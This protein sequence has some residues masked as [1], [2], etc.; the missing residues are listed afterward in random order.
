MSN[1]FIFEIL[2]VK[3]SG[4]FTSQFELSTIFI[5]HLPEFKIIEYFHEFDRSIG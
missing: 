2:S 3:F 1:K 5:L 4:D